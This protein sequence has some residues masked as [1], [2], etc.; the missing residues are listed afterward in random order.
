MS[1][2][3]CS[4]TWCPGSWCYGLCKEKVHSVSSVTLQSSTPVFCQPV[5]WSR[6]RTAPEGDLPPYLTDG[7]LGHQ[8]VSTQTI[9]YLSRETNC[10]LWCPGTR[11]VDN[12]IQRVETIPSGTKGSGWRCRRRPRVSGSGESYVSYSPVSEEG[13]RPLD[14]RQTSV[15]SVQ[16]FLSPGQVWW[17]KK[18]LRDRLSTQTRSPTVNIRQVLSRRVW[19]KGQSLSICSSSRRTLTGGSRSWGRRIKINLRVSTK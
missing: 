11:R 15:S 8:T 10:P 4:R 6:F 17:D 9:V 3:L 18:K 14:L 16:D 5:Q 13:L 1:W 19:C 2:R 12:K 7:P